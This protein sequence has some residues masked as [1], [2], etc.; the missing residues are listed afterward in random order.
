M[1]YSEFRH[2]F[3][4]TESF[5]QA[6]GRLTEEE[7]R[8]LVDADDSPTFIKACMMTTWSTARRKVKLHHVSVRLYDDCSLTIVFYEYESEFDGND[9]EYYYSLDA[10]TTDAFIKM[11]PRHWSDAETNIEEWLIDNIQ[12]DGSG[13]DLRDKWIRMGL[14]GSCTVEEDFPGGIYREETF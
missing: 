14:H 3:S 1:N 13:I 5:M 11:I 6:Y 8:A 9:F 7:A 10:D 2:Q 4:S 12:C